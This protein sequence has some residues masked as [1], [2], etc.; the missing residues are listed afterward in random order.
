MVAQS[1]S[2]VFM[3]AREWYMRYEGCPLRRDL[4]EGWLISD[5]CCDLKAVCYVKGGSG[6][7]VKGGSDRLGTFSPR[8]S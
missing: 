7:F 4:Q 5:M 2:A 8:G 1:G 3:V 6:E